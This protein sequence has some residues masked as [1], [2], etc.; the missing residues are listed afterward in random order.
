MPPPPGKPSTPDTNASDNSSTDNAQTIFNIVDLAKVDRSIPD[1]PLAT[2]QEAFLFEEQWK[3]KDF[4]RQLN[5]INISHNIN[6]N[7]TSGVCHF[8]VSAMDLVLKNL[9]HPSWVSPISEVPWF[10]K[11]NENRYCN[12]IS[13]CS[14]DECGC[15][16]LAKRM[17]CSSVQNALDV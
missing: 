12:A 4:S 8:P 14:T 2:C 7:K 17:Q 11:I 5:V 16:N 6:A 10:C 9:I 13:Q 1:K 15:T 3:Y